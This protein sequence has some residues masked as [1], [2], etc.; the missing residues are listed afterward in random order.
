MRRVH[1]S[2]ADAPL[3]ER[4]IR[5]VGAT[6][7][8]WPC[9]AKLARDHVVLAAASAAAVAAIRTKGSNHYVSM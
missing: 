5:A 7:L 9:G 1:A 8:A 6:L 4:A 3:V 2:R